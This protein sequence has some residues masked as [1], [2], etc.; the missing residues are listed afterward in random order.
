MAVLVLS[1]MVLFAGSPSV[2]ASG[3]GSSSSVDSV[4]LKSGKWVYSIYIDK[5]KTRYA[6]ITRYDGDELNVVIPSDFDG[7]PVKTVSREAFCNNKYMTSVLIPD[8]VT[9]IGKYA[10]SGCVGLGKVNYSS[11]LTTIG[12]GAFYGCWSLTEAVFPEGTQKIGSFSFYNCRHLKKIVFPSSLKSIGNSAFEG[13]S[14]LESVSFGENLETVGDTAFKGCTSLT[15]A[16]VSSVKKLGTGAFMKCAGLETVVI[17]DHIG[18]IRPETFR[19]CVSLKSVVFGKDLKTI[20]VSAFEGCEALASLPVINPLESIASLAFKGCVSLRTAEIGPEVSKIGFC[21]F[22]GCAALEKISVSE[23]NESFSSFN[24]CLYTKDRTKLLLCPQG[25]KGKLKTDENISVIGDYAAAGCTSVRGA[26]LGENTLEIGRAA[27][28]GCT[29]VTALSVPEKVEKIGSAALGMYLFGGKMKK[30]DYLKIYGGAGSAAESYCSQREMTFIPYSST[31]YVSS[32]RVVLEEKKSFNLTCGFSSGKK[33]KITWESSDESVVTVKDGKLHAVSQGNAE[34]TASAEG[35]DPAAVKVSVVQARGKKAA[36]SKSTVTRLI[37]CGEHEGLG[38]LLSQLIDPIFSSDRYW[39][40]SAPAVASVNNDGEVFAHSRGNA[41]VTCHMPDGSETIFIVTVTEKPTELT[42]IAPDDELIIGE[43]KSILKNLYPSVSSDV[44]T[45]ETDNQNI[46]TVDA[47]GRITAVG[48]G[49]CTVTA[50]AESGLKSSVSVRCVIPAEKITLDMDARNVYQGKEFNLT[51]SLTPQNSSQKIRWSSSD[52]SVASVNSKGKVT[53]KSFG[54]AVIIARTSLG[55][56]AEC[57][58]NVIAKAEELVLDVKNLSINC[59]SVYK[60]NALIRPSYS[61]ETTDSCTWNT[62]D[63]SVAVV[64]EEGNVTAVGPGRCIINC[65]TSGDL[66]SKCRLQVNLPAESVEI[67]SEKDTLYIGEVLQLK[68]VITPEKST[69]SLEWSSSDSSVARVTS[70][71]SVKG[72]SV[73]TAVIT[74]KVTNGV[75][76]E[77]VTATFEI[78]ILKKADSVKLSQ[79][80]L[81]LLCGEKNFLTYTLLPDDSNDTVAWSS[82]DESVASVRDDGLITAIAPGTCYIRI[83]TGSGSSAK[84]KVTVK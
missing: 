52:P 54:T 77:S 78:N 39:Y 83:E 49:E 13:C 18:D 56:T 32:E 14:M 23:K 46:A 3:S 43:K 31:L 53:G 26:E 62:T 55:V 10:F 19:G 80:S 16:D 73:G 68:A 30:V 71:G 74:A 42:L 66:I 69:D 1:A 8:S 50:I 67:N 37:Y 15:K 57:R 12:E 48:Q 70:G 27:F 17:G 82:T 22:G 7:I 6:A 61:P 40:S 9:E 4:N 34:V 25:F 51:A 35:F 5:N 11:S 28:L 65:R 79:N 33:G 21:A 58:V 47:D 60:L 2:I 64:D 72:V 38:S 36:N 59:G 24:G 45:W 29:D 63:E 20:G 84:C 41:A 81:S 44:I 75:T 76:N